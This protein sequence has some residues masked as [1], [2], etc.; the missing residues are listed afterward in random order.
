MAPHQPFGLELLEGLNKN[1]SLTFLRA[2]NFLKLLIELDFIPTCM[3]E[4]AKYLKRGFLHEFVMENVK[5]QVVLQRL[6]GCTSTDYLP[7]TIFAEEEEDEKVEEMAPEFG[8][9]P[10]I[11]QEDINS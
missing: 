6:L 5:N 10:C 8:F 4:V 2:G 7:F 11:E 9:R 1:T 3:D